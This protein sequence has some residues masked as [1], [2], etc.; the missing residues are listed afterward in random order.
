[1]CIHMC[2]YMWVYIYAIKMYVYT[3]D[4]ISVR[5]REEAMVLC[6]TEIELCF[7]DIYEKKKEK[8][9]LLHVWFIPAVTF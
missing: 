4:S 1:M 8:E 3:H 9:V 5:L 7:R 2:N 6:F